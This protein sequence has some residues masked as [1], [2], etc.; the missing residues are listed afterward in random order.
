MCAVIDT[1]DGML[2]PLVADDD[3]V[4]VLSDGKLAEVLEFT[5]KAVS[6]TD[7]TNSGE[8]SPFH[9]MCVILPLLDGEGGE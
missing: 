3:L 9:R 8:R 2:V 4:S 1:N 7:W 6:I 5:H